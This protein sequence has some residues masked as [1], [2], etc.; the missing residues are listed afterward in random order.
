[1]LGYVK[2]VKNVYAVFVACAWS[3]KMRRR[4]GS[5]APLRAAPDHM[6]PHC[7]AIVRM[8]LFLGRPHHRFSSARPPGE[9]KHPFAGRSREGLYNRTRHSPRRRCCGHIAPRPLVHFCLPARAA[10]FVG[11]FG[12]ASFLVRQRVWVCRCGVAF[13]GEFLLVQPPSPHPACIITLSVRP[14][15]SS[16]A[17]RGN[18]FGSR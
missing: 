3:Q 2:E 11:C 12:Q 17:L 7:P 15:P 1:M 18:D 9:R 16:D 8:L 14:I 5:R 13:V 6:C 10:C 4:S